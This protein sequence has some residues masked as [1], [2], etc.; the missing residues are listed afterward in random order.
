MARVIRGARHFLIFNFPCF[1]PL[2][3]CPR[4]YRCTRK[5]SRA[6]KVDLQVCVS[7]VVVAI[8]FFSPAT[9][10]QCYFRCDQLIFMF[11]IF[12]GKMFPDAF[13]ALFSK[14]YKMVGS[15]YSGRA[16]WLSIAAAAY[17]RSVSYSCAVN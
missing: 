9:Y 13:S 15:L 7:R 14:W 4:G 5:G 12:P 1:V 6:S 11:P 3:R 10:E 8:V 16:C 2:L 17:L